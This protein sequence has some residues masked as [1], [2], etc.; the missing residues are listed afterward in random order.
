MKVFRL[1]YQLQLEIFE[2]TKSFPKEERYPLID[3][4]RCS[5]KP[6][7]TNIAEARYKRKHSNMLI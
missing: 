1:A 5:S 4:V 7:C 2:L 3:Q 6:V